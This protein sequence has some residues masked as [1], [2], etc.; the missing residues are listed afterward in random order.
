MEPI[1]TVDGVSPPATAATT[2]ATP[3]TVGPGAST[4]WK[5]LIALVLGV[6]Y[7]LYVFWCLFL[8][9]SLPSATAS[10]AFIMAGVVSSLVGG[11]VLL[12][13]SYVIFMRIGSSKA[14][15]NAK[16]MALIKLGVFAVPG[17]V[18][19]AATGFMISREPQL[20]IAI[21]SPTSTDQF[22]APLT[23]TFSVAETVELLKGRGFTPIQF[24]WDINGDNQID[25]Q[26]L[27]PEL[28]ATYDREGIKTIRVVMRSSDGD[29]R[30]ASRRF[31]IS[32]S[33]FSVT[34]LPAI[35]ERPVVFSLAQLYPQSDAVRTVAWDFDG[36]GNVDDEGA[37]LQTS[38]T[39]LNTGTFTVSAVASLANNTQIR[40]ERTIA[41]QEEPPLPFPVTVTS[42]P[43]NLIGT[44]PFAALFSIDTDE[45]VHSVQWDFGDGQKGEG[46]R[47]THTFS[48]NGS[49]GV[50]ARVRST[51]GVIAEV[52]TLVKVVDELRLNDLRF[53]GSPQV[54]SNRI[55]GE[56]PLTLDL[57]P[58]T[59]TPF[60]D[61]VWEA[62]DATEIGSTDTRLQAIYRRPGTYTVTLVGQDQENHVL[63]LP[64]EVIVEPPSSVITFQ[65]SPETGIAPLTV[66]FDASASEIPG[67]EI[68]GFIWDFRDGSEQEY[69]GAFSQHVFTRPGTYT[70]NLTARTTSGKQ[71][72][73]TKTLVVRAPSL[74]PR[75][76]ASRL[77]GT[78]PLTVAFD[79]SPSSGVIANYEWN[80]GDNTQNDGM[81][82][83]HT[84]LDPGTYTVIL[85]V[86]DAA[87]ASSSTT[88]TITVQ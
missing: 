69:G 18:L 64:I 20:S 47:V 45:P 56:V 49:Y 53:E 40:Y 37:S 34:P 52:N 21:T 6:P 43:N 26:T 60:V 22:V 80:F 31:L 76:L 11:V 54:Q 3:P 13:V 23:M 82:V 16:L 29:T 5:L 77:S 85:T 84:F 75:I 58:V 10:D 46:Q 70:V 24:A 88:A 78:A 25:Q 72:S 68:T 63:R 33:V 36:D 62:P 42:Q 19:S 2:P 66:K 8:L 38:F 86:R 73:A 1:S 50:V 9:A 55:S 30:N 17:L 12:A 7:L 41:V 32:R 67:E 59:Q 83:E 28:T 27:S 61:F 15:P 48:R 4:Q 35:V 87:G 71:Q 51:S 14:M 79:A 81:Q 39:Y 57:R 74:Q 44:A 65:M